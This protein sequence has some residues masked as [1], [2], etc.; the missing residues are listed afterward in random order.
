MSNVTKEQAEDALKE[1]DVSR[2]AW[3]IEYLEGTEVKE[4][5][6]GDSLRGP[7]PSPFQS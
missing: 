6:A 4:T 7:S 2:F 3:T 1:V 5:V